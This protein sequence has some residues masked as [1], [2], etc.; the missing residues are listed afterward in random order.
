MVCV[1]DP[2]T[3]DGAGTC[4]NN[5]ESMTA[6]CRPALHEC[7]AAE[8][9]DGE[10]RCRPDALASEGT[11]CGDASSGLCDAPDSCD[12]AGTCL[13]NFQPPSTQCRGAAGDCGAVAF[14]DGS[15]GCPA[16]AFA[17]AGTACGDPSSGPCDS[18][19]SCDGA[20]T[21]L[22]NFLPTSTE[23]RVAAGACDVAEF[24]DGAG[25]C[26]ADVFA[27]AGTACGDPSGGL[28]DAPDTCDGAGACFSNP[29]PP[30]TECRGAINECDVAEFCDGTGSCPPDV[31]AEAGAACGDDTSGLCDAPDSCDGAGT[32]QRNNLP[33]TTQCRVAD[34]VC[35][36]AELC[37]GEG[38]C[39]SDVFVGAGTHC[40]NGAYCDGE[41]VCDGRGVCQSGAPPCQASCNEDLDTCPCAHPVCE[42][43]IPLDSTCGNGCAALVC[44]QNPSCC[45][46]SWNDECVCV[47]ASLGCDPDCAV[48]P[49]PDL[50]VES[51][52]A[53]DCRPFSEGFLAEV[54]IRVRNQGCEAAPPFEIAVDYDPDPPGD[55]QSTQPIGAN[56]TSEPLAPGA[57]I[58][59]SGRLQTRNTSFA[60][61][62]TWALADSCFADEGL[63]DWCRVRESDESN[64]ESEPVALTASECF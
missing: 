62:V 6:E 38:R 12:G 43:G 45:T 31:F 22:T 41:E 46:D 20:G 59:F 51:Y 4:Q 33:S 47:A 25:G 48:R 40:S 14:C 16:I 3:C 49:E 13:A 50:V 60:N 32:C 57:V 26:P 35:D 34:G 1:T 64:N 52:T 30:S 21:C 61:M 9:C 17:P 2:D 27:N 56:S 19:D 36:V 10:G 42:V 23:C 53:E 44:D 37:D 29:E 15:G 55:R 5:H 63:P 39:P 11:A 58:T 8:S 54:T 7:D 24:C 18:P 28:C